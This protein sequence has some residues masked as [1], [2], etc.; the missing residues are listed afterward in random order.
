MTV[1]D[2]IK[3]LDRKV[4]QNEAQYDLDRKAAKIS[5]LSSNNLDKYEYLTG[6]DLGLKP[7][8]VEQTK[9]EYSP[10]GKI[11]HKRLS[12]DDKKEGLFKRLENIK[13]TS[14]TQLQAIKDQGEKKLREL[15]NIDESKTLEA[16]DEIRRKND[17]AKDLVSKIKK[18]DTELDTAEL[19]S[20]KT[21]GKTKYQFNIFTI[22]LKF[23]RKINNYEINLD[24]AVDDQEKL[25]NSIIRLE[26]YK[27]RKTNKQKKT[28]EK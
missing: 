2:Q 13:D 24:E 23:A 25:E 15:K 4:M 5:A 7:S 12:E 20:T 27:P 16:I 26:N 22:P 21:D 8:T 6:Q 11:F 19:V 9:F 18:I 14:L 3:I 28:R 17:E 10:L 1:T